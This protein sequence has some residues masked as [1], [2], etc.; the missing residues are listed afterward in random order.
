MGWLVINKGHDF[1]TKKGE[2][3][4]SDDFAG[5]NFPKITYEDG[6]IEIEICKSGKVY[7]YE[8]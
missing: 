2:K 7:W 5:I 1:I 3:I 8:S 6:P 4:S